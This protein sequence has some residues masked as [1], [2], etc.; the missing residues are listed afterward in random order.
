[1][2]TKMSL[3]RPVGANARTVSLTMGR[4]QLFRQTARLKTHNDC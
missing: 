3:K 1:M 2:T 4:K